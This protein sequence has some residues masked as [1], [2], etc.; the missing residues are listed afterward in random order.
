MKWPPKVPK[1]FPLT[2]VDRGYIARIAG[3]PRWICGR[4]SPE[5]ALAIYHKKA[6]SL[7]AGQEPLPEPELS[8]GIVTVHYILA[9]W[10]KVRQDDVR[11]NLLRPAS[12][13]QFRNSCKRIDRIIGHLS[14]GAVDS[15]LVHQ[16][17]NRIAKADGVDAARRAVSH[18]ATACADAAEFGWCRPIA[19]GRR[20]KKL[21]ARPKA[22]MAWKL[23]TPAEIRMI[24]DEIDRR[25]DTADGRSLSSWVQFKAMVLLALN[26]GYGAMELSEL[27]KA[28]VD[29]DGAQID[30]RRGKTGEDHIVPLW[31]RT[32]EALKPV[33]LQ[34]P[35][36][37]LL[38]RTREGNPW[39][40]AEVKT[41]NG[42]IG[43]R[44]TDRCNERYRDI[45]ESLGIRTRGQGF[46]KLKH[47]HCTIA[48]AAGDPH[49]TFTLAGHALFG[50]K[51]SYV[52]VSQE[53]V[54]RVVEFIESHLFNPKV[55]HPKQ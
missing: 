10:L 3:K 34:R 19:L 33:L 2:V 40:M 43:K 51:S 44:V 49:A 23:H 28:V 14:I 42:K 20:I 48:D 55:D 45:A 21:A 47:L 50:K 8:N 13:L 39:C 9:K 7:T 38:F 17:F 11:T 22:K 41:V 5:D 32:V 4:Q 31:D 54:R 25:I 27:P 26:G 1:T 15:E 46:Y 6:A 24:V 52:L 30:Y 36:D 12:Y 29:L 18:F 53:R 37:P 35:G 16:V